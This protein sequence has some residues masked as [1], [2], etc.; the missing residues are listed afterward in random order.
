MMVDEACGGVHHRLEPL[1]EML[2]DADECGIT[3]VQVTENKYNPPVT[4]VLVAALN[5]G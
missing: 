4:G 3:E 1:Q 2:R 5:D